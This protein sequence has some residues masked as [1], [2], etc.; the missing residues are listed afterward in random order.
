MFKAIQ[1]KKK[2]IQ[3]KAEEDAKN[4]KLREEADRRNANWSSADLSLL[5]KSVVKFPS[6]THQRWERII[7]HMGNK[8]T[9]E[10]IIE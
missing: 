4:E 6:G 8:F 9:K 7:R 2:D 3:K 5:S 10:Q 1:K